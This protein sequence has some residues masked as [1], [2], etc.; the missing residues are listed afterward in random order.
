LRWQAG[1]LTIADDASSNGTQVNRQPLV[2]RRPYPLRK[3]DEIQVGQTVLS[4]EMP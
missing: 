4:V 3:G 2:P 1:T